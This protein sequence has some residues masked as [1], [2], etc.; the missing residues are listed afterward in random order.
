V[1][2]EAAPARPP[3]RWGAAGLLKA[4]L[5]AQ[6]ALAVLVVIGDLP[7]DVLQ[8]LPGT[9]APSPALETPV[10][11]G[12]QTRRYTPDDMVTDRPAFPGLPAG[13]VPSRLEFTVITTAGRPGTVLLNGAIVDGDATRLTDWLAARP[14][15]PAAF[16]LNSPGG[17]VAEALEIGRILRRTGQPV[18]I[19]PEAYCL[20]ACPYILAGGIEREVSRQA[21]V[22]VHQ[23]YFGENTFLPAFLMVS[24][25]QAG[26]GAVMAYLAEMGIDPLLM[27]KALV[28]PPD[29]IYIL[30]P[31]E[32]QTFRLATTLTD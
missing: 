26:Q 15:S 1:T 24:D 11:P 30:L 27:A 22:G 25:I 20:S 6:C 13:P 14:E 23:H 19:G 16:T 4:M 17:D 18:L 2:D 10:T 32:L 12:N 28:T 21:H 9:A 7:A 8:S 31:E 29:D 3:G 5:A